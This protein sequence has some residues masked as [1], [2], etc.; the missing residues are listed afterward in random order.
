M[1]PRVTATGVFLNY[2]NNSEIEGNRVAGGAEKCLFI[3]NANINR[4]HDNYFADCQIGIHFTAGSERNE[5]YPNAFVNNRT[6]VKYVGTRDIEWSLN[7]RGNYWSDNPAFDLDDD[8]IADQAYR[9][10]TSSTR[11]S[12]VILWRSC[13]STARPCRC[14]GGPSPRFRRCIPAA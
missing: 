1:S 9:P 5:V 14:S 7:G 11:L 13:C 12:G 4:I 10:M 2:A 8:G 3:Y 6:Q